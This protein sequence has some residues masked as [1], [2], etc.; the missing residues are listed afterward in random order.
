MT[1]EDVPELRS[2]APHQGGPLGSSGAA[3][4]A[5]PGGSDKSDVGA[6]E[7]TAPSSPEPAKPE[8]A[9]PEPAK[10]E[11]ASPEPASPEPAKPE[12][13]KPEPAKPEPAKPEA[14]GDG[15]AKPVIPAQRGPVEV[16]DA[17]KTSPKEDD[18]AKKDAVKNDASAK[19]AQP[20]KSDDTT[21][22]GVA[23]DGVAKDGSGK[24]GS[25]KDTAAKDTAA[26]DTA[27][28][29]T[30]AA[31]P[32]GKKARRFRP[33]AAVGRAGR[34]TGSWA[35]GPVGRVVLPGL[36]VVGLVV[37]AGTSGAYL[38]PRALD[39]AAPTATPT[40]AGQSGAPGVNPSDPA[41]LPGG[42]GVTGTGLPTAPAGAA[43]GLPP[44][45]PTVTG[46]RPA[47]A[48]ASWAQQVGT[49]VGI[50]VVAVQAYGYAEL[51]TA[52]TTPSCHLS[53][54]TLAAIGKVESGHGSH[55]GAVLGVDG[56][57]SP[58][59]YGL[60][61]DGQG[62]RQLIRDTDQGVVDRDTTYDRA[63][64]PMQFIP[65][66]WQA[67]EIDADNDG[68][69]NPNDIDDAAMTAAA[70]LCKG[71]R[72]LSKADSWWDAVLTYNDVR[73]YAQE[74]FTTANDYGLRSRT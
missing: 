2:S 57:A 4:S 16:A 72:D 44:V 70:Y 17:D 19:D 21:K 8:P 45:Q 68:V 22:D 6:P 50:P 5:D 38:V 23:K 59:I 52:K 11:P 43:T 51:V 74:V 46:A 30:A 66:T 53:W 61:L 47:D 64:G 60:P 67:M 34:A 73:P 31:A 7:S 9:S 40:F 49:R 36:V 33:V 14:A 27:A 62:G 28:K 35:R 56:N 37:L 12:P 10:P 69:K 3:P 41:A 25:G 42:P 26:K 55:E 13:A 20:A 63:V 58:T 18:A 39:A 71:G 24:D 65:S 15:A 32:A 54:T 29:G 48:L 1:P